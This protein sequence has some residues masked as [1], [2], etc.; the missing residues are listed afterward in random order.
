MYEVKPWRFIYAAKAGNIKSGMERNMRSLRPGDIYSRL[1]SRGASSPYF[2]PA[3]LGGALLVILTVLLNKFLGVDVGLTVVI[4]VGVG[5]V[6]IVTMTI[7][8]AR[9][10]KRRLQEEREK[11]YQEIEAMAHEKSK[12]KRDAE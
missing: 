10:S 8:A 1:A 4:A 11:F 3:M 7:R 5:G 2:G 6:L 12:E 9:A